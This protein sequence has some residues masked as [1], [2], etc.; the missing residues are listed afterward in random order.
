MINH[1]LCDIAKENCKSKQ[2]DLLYEEAVTIRLETGAVHPPTGT[3]AGTRGFTGGAFGRRHTALAG[4]SGKNLREVFD[5]KHCRKCG[6]AL[7]DEARAC[8]HCGVRLDGEGGASDAPNAA[9]ALL[10]FFFPVVGLAVL[11]SLET[12]RPLRA[13]SARRGI[14]AALALY[15]LIFVLVVVLNIVYLFGE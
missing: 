4:R 9:V 13:R 5:M 7:V 15:A 10:A 6:G 1:K 12:I 3:S 11:F 14:Y 8:I 2:E